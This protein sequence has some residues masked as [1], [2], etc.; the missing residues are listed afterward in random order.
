MDSSLRAA[1]PRTST[2]AALRDDR[3]ATPSELG[4]DPRDPAFIADPQELALQLA[5]ANRDPATF[6]R[7]DEIVL[8]RSPN[9]YLSFGAGI[10]YCLGAPVAKVEFDILFRRMLS[11]LPTMELVVDPRR[12]PRFI[13]RGPDSLPVRT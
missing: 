5:A 12:K 7:P 6:D 3:G 4:D 9:P 2:G 13:L 10:H 1:A 11:D 8:D